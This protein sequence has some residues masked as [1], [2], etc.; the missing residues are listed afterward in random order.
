MLWNPDEAPG[1]HESAIAAEQERDDKWCAELA[2]AGWT[3]ESYAEFL[4]RA[5]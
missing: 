5:A 3:P 4:N 1:E 2:E